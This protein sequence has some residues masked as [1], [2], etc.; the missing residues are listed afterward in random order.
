MSDIS[1]SRCSCCRIFGEPSAR[2]NILILTGAPYLL[3]YKRIELLLENHLNIRTS[4][5]NGF[6][7][8]YQTLAKTGSNIFNTEQQSLLPNRSNAE[9]VTEC[10]HGFRFLSDITDGVSGQDS[11]ESIETFIRENL[12]QPLPSDGN[13]KEMRHE[14]Y[15]W[16]ILHN[17]IYMEPKILDIFLQLSHTDVSLLTFTFHVVCF[18]V[19]ENRFFESWIRMKQIIQHYQTNAFPEYQQRVEQFFDKLNTSVS[20]Q[21]QTF[22]VEEDAQLTDSKLLQ[23]LQNIFIKNNPTCRACDHTLR[24]HMKSLL[25]SKHRTV[26]NLRT[27]QSQLHIGYCR[28]IE[29]QLP[30]MLVRL[31]E[32]STAIYA[33]CD[34]IY[35]VL[36]KFE[37]MD[38]EEL[39]A[40]KR[41][42][43]FGT[44][45]SD[46]EYSNTIISQ[47]IHFTLDLLEKHA[48]TLTGLIY[49][50]VQTICVLGSHPIFC[51]DLFR[52]TPEIYTLS[53]RLV[54]QRKYTLTLMGIR[55]CSTI[56]QADQT[57]YK[58][59][60]AYLENDRLA[61]KK[62]LSAIL[63]LLSPYHTLKILEDNHS[64]DD[65]ATDNTSR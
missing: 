1:Q 33:A 48:N 44:G 31:C 16:I 26:H 46:L 11:Y 6:L 17:S 37:L 10:C 13:N 24:S 4:I 36:K 55:L 45:N 25:R 27:V 30:A 35:L 39:R 47:L 7:P 57:E 40:Y 63:W 3:V 59:S 22:L 23:L 43:I 42:L 34:V 20:L 38:N 2:V 52:H 54:E 64:D 41:F 5:E 62:V 58:Y 28:Q 51:H 21:Q 61:A 18:L 65:E 19:D 9:A 50:S 53:L 60:M 14:P 15:S 12:H 29:R 8:V 56:L 32:R 49:A